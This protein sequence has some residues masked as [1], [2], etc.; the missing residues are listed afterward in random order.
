MLELLTRKAKTAV[1]LVFRQPRQLVV[2]LGQYGIF[3]WLPDR[4]CLKL[5]YWAEMGERLD[6]D[7]PKIFSQKLQWLKIHDRQERY[8]QMVDK[9]AVREWMREKYGE[10]YLIPLLGTYNHPEEIEW[11]N[12]PDQFVIKCTHGSGCNLVCKNKTSFDKSFACVQIKAWMKKNW[13]YFGREWPYKNVRPRI[14]IERFVSDGEDASELTDYKFYCFEGEP[15]YCQ[16]IG[17]RQV[18]NDKAVYYIDFYDRNWTRMPF[19]GMK[20]NSPHAPEERKKPKSHEVMLRVA[21]ELAEGTHFVRIDFYEIDGQ[22]KF[23]EFTLYPLSGFGE[24]EPEEWN[25]TLGDLIKLP[26]DL[27]N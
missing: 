1:K 26:T 23:G 10:E 27:S 13:F 15:V 5:V 18:K 22:P 8:P 6:L 17:G 20:R 19:S 14:I 9:Y 4:A 11:E 2:A 12:L 7:R 25:Q 16:V 24:F 3:N 21:R